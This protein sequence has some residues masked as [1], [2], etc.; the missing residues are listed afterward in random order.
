MVTDPK[1]GGCIDILLEYKKGGYTLQQ[2]VDRFSKISGMRE[3][4]TR[5]YI[6]SM[7]RDNIVSLSAK[8]DVITK[9]KEMSDEPDIAG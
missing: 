1:I 4:I 8:R 7:A 2:A 3:D 9:Q 5:E 6:K